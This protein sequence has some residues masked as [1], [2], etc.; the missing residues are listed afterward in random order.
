MP[1]TEADVQALMEVC[2]GCAVGEAAVT[3]R[4]NAVR[5]YAKL[6]IELQQYYVAVAQQQQQ[7]Q[8]DE[9]EI[10][11]ETLPMETGEEGEEDLE[12]ET[13][14]GREEETGQATGPQEEE[15]REEGE[16]LREKVVKAANA[17]E[18]NGEQ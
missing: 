7:Q 8:Q 13:T 14:D 9:E 5:L 1:L 17:K 3:V 15:T 18:E 6:G 2:M 11:Q 10:P 16:S 4:E 12:V